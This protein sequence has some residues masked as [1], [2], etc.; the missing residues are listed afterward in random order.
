MQESMATSRLL[1]LLLLYLVAVAP[2]GVLQTRAQPDSNGFISIDCGLAGPSYVDETNNLTYQPDAAFTDAGENHNI[3]SYNVLLGLQGLYGDLRSFPNGTRNCYTLRS[4]TAGNKYL[5]RAS[6]MY[7]YYDGL[8]IPPVFDLYIG[9]NYWATV[10]GWSLE[11]SALWW[12]AI[13]V[14]ADNSVQ[15]CLVK[16]GATTPFISGL[17]LRPLKSSMYPQVNVTQGL[18]VVS[19]RSMGQTGTTIRYPDDPYDR[20]WQPTKINTTRWTVISTEETVRNYDDDKF[21]APSKVL[22]TAITPR[23]APY[24]IQFEWCLSANPSSGCI[25][26]FYFSELESLPSKAVRQFYININDNPP[27]EGYTPPYLYSG[28]VF[29]TYPYRGYTKYT[30]MINATANSTLPPIINA[31][32]SFYVIST[33]KF[34]TDS[35]DVS[36]ITA[37][38]MNYGVTKNW[39]GDPCDTVAWFGLTCSSAIA[40]PSRITGANMSFSSL[41]GDISSAFANLTAVQYMDLSYNNLTGSIPDALSQLLSLTTLDLTGNNLSGSIPPGLLKKIQAGSLNLRYGNNP[42]LCGNGNSC[43]RDKV[44]SRLAIYTVALVV[45]ALVVVSAVVTYILLRRKKQEWV[46]NSAKPQK[47]ETSMSHVPTGDYQSSLRLENR[48]FTYNELAMITNNFQHVLG[49]GGFG[50]VYNGFLEDGTQVAVKLRSESSTQG[51]REFLTEV[52]ILTRIHHKNLVS[53]IGYC[54]DEDYMALVY[55]YM[56]EGTLQ[57]HIIEK[58]LTWRQRLRIALE[59]AEGLEY[60]HKGCNP[61]LIHRD[62]KT[63][64]ILL[65]GKLEAKVADFGLS[66]A[67]NRDMYTHVSTNT[68][69]GTVGYVDPEYQSTLQLTVK[70]DVF[71]FGVVLLELVTGK[72]A[73]LRDPEPIGVIQWTKLRLARGEIESIVDERMNGD[74]DINS[75]W[76]VANVALACTAQASM[77]RPTMT[78]VVA[79]LQECLELEEGRA[80]GGM[81]QSFYTGNNDDLNSSYNTNAYT[82]TSA[83]Q[84]SPVFEMVERMVIG[85]ATR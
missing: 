38:K 11:R 43:T 83:S 33:A 5:F 14:V 3:P 16:T 72:Q 54:K 78:D 31:F 70:S 53:M 79:Q 32:E 25:H 74:H 24:N 73:I 23:I 44:K 69:V 2:D 8:V 84:S 82:A 19:R 45:M 12:E 61:P 21:E 52:Q 13:V 47:N 67:F 55:E 39:M 34:G 10:E 37:I 6:F 41:N 71:S 63:T 4:L 40:A 35:Q 64:N 46:N 85:P 75:V 49:R 62:V 58:H 1:W 76:K 22:Q 56:S 17:E 60:L 59:S 27:G 68:L 81:T 29:N 15:V 50:Y 57:E 26:V 80:G 77:Q 48:R 30:V 9:L 42:N 20:I 65:N 51:V 7:G 28:A 18:V 66:K 36:A